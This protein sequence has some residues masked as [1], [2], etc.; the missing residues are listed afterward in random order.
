MAIRIN[1]VYTRTGDDGRT[2][3]VGGERVP[4]DDPRIAAYG[5]VD[6]LNSVVGLARALLAEPPYKGRV[7]ARHLDETLAFIQ[8]E[9]FDLGSELATPPEAEYEGMLHVG[10]QQVARLE[11]FIDELQGDLEPLKSFVLPGGGT[12]G[13]SLHLARTV[14]RRA[15][16]LVTPLVREQ[17]AS[18]WTARYLNRLSDLLFVQSR[19]IARKT[20]KTETLWQHGL[21]PPK[22]RAR[23][24]RATHSKARKR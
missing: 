21:Q 23:P 13:A 16:R 4:K 14:C 5:E 17:Q 6:E 20:G 19:W 10:E 24:S 3:L 9:L 22:A 11:A 15:E 18:A 12:A 8:Q 2:A 7:A 1:R